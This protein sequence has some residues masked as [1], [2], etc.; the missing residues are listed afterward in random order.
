MKRTLSPFAAAF[1]TLL[2]APL[3]FADQ[4]VT[5]ADLPAPARQTVQREVG[6]GQI[7]DIEREEEGGSVYYEVEF[8]AANRD[9][10]IDVAPDGKL[11]RREN[12]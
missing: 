12:D 9:Y 4:N 5:L 8:T 1:V 3:A 10:E 11:L 6:A 2:T 7:T